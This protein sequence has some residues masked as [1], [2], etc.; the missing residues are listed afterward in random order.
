MNSEPNGEPRLGQ[1]AANSA[2]DGG[3]GLSSAADSPRRNPAQS[4]RGLR[5]KRISTLRARE[6]GSEHFLQHRPAPCQAHRDLNEPLRIMKFGGTSVGD[7]SCIAR[8]V[9]IITAAARETSMCVVVSAMAGVTNRL[10]EAASKAEAGQTQDF[11]EIL[12]DLRSQH[13]TA[14]SALIESFEDRRQI[15]NQM[16]RLFEEGERLCQG[17]L[18]LRELTPRVRDAVSSLGERLSAPLMSAALAQ[19]GVRSV[20]IEATEL[21]VTDSCHGA[22]DPWMD[23]TRERCEICLRPLL[24][25]GSV[26]IVTGFIGASPEGILTTL[27]RGGSDYSATILGAALDADEVVI[28]SDVDGLMTADPRLVPGACTIAEI[29]Y[30]EAAELAYFG[31][32]VLHP[33]T[34]RAVMRHGIPLWIRNTFAPELPGTKITPEG[35]SSGGGV[36][37]LTAS[38][39][40]ALITVGGQGSVGVPDVLGRTFATT[41]A[42]RAD[43]L[44]I[45]QAS[46]QNDICLVVPSADA[47]RTVDA[48]RHEFAQDLAHENVEHITVD[49]TIA[50]VTVVGQNMKAT[51]AI[52]GRT[53]AALGRENV[54]IIAISQGSSECNISFVVPKE[55]VEKALVTTHREF[56]LALVNS[57]H[58]TSCSV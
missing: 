40:V 1:V 30:R 38:R 52:I 27:G 17:T 16:H 54:N 9:E 55:D 44:L 45:S 2:T 39:D 15:L 24:Q 3:K 5:M 51:P 22:A 57:Q 34:L 4:T 49:S 19:N 25:Q 26:P 58:L 46:S 42:V 41:S 12:D 21:I 18:L 33:K 14:V 13:E 20:A 43:V 37:S 53:F 50:I 48:L 32:K 23:L 31:A 35:L 11:A 56:D 6:I 7:A 47:T 29:S 8:V 28:W 10:I 36:R